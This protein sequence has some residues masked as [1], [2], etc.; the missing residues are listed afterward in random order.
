MLIIFVLQNT[1]DLSVHFLIFS[2]TMRRFVLIFL[3]L[4]IGFFAG[5]TFR[6]QFIDK[7]DITPAEDDF[8]DV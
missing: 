4:L 2:F 1:Q 8:T 7:K 3:V 6:G 5:W